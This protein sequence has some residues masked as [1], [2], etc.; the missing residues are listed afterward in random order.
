MTRPSGSAACTG[1]A[2]RRSTG[3]RASGSTRSRRCR[4]SW[5]CCRRQMPGGQAV[6]RGRASNQMTLWLS[7]CELTPCLP[8]LICLPPRPD[9]QPS[10]ANPLLCLHAQ[11]A[12]W[13]LSS[14]LSVRCGWGLAAEP[15]RA[16]QS[17]WAVGGCAGRKTTRWRTRTQC[18]PWAS[19]WSSIRTVWTRSWA[20]CFCRRSLSRQMQVSHPAVAWEAAE[21]LQGP[22]P[23]ALSCSLKYMCM[24][25]SGCQT[26]PLCACLR[27]CLCAPGC[28]G[29]QGGARAAAAVHPVVGPAHTGGRKRQPAAHRGG[30]CQGKW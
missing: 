5:P 20:R 4:P 16:R 24:H 17:C 28:S 23:P 11:R 14:T 7:G 10:N 22:F 26:A 13:H 21:P 25:S 30:A 6:V 15:G 12:G 3:R 1:W 29:G 19:C 27:V 9:F 2:R 18:R 8:L